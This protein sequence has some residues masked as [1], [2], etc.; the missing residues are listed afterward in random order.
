MG[1]KR[2][3]KLQKLN[4]Q[5]SNCECFAA[6]CSDTRTRMTF[7]TR[8]VWSVYKWMHEGND[9]ALGTRRPTDVELS[10]DTL[11]GTSFC[12]LRQIDSECVRQNSN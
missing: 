12:F 7:A 6:K 4:R 8:W 3:I 5:L 10:I 1:T 9:T 11:N 2:G